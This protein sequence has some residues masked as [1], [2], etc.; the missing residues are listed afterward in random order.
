[1]VFFLCFSNLNFSRTKDEKSKLT[2]VAWIEEI[3][4]SRHSMLPSLTSQTFRF[5][6][7]SFNY[8]F[9]VARRSTRKIKKV[10]SSL[11]SFQ[12]VAVG[13][14][15]SIRNWRFLSFAVCRHFFCSVVFVSVSSIAHFRRFFPRHF[16]VDD[17]VS[18]S[19]FVV[20][21]LFSKLFAVVFLLRI[22]FMTQTDGSQA[23]LNQNSKENFI[24]FV[25]SFLFWRRRRPFTVVQC[26]SFRFRFYSLPSV[27]PSLKYQYNKRSVLIWFSLVWCFLT[28]S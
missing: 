4:I 18:V 13:R 14:R 23:V 1:M 28:L 3:F 16:L 17:F 26:S 25:I 6:L 7:S 21:R 9:P 20:F 15:R 24:T 27:L 5:S 22:K 19:V 12:V 10:F 2:L 8:Q 11:N